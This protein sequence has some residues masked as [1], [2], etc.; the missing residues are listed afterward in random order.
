MATEQTEINSI[1]SGYDK[2]M[3]ELEKNII[4]PKCHFTFMALEFSDNEEWWECKHCG[5]TQ[6]R[7]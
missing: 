5:H 1:M 6:E 7:K 4:P 2:L 3:T